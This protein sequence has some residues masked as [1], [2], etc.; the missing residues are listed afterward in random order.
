MPDPTPVSVRLIEVLQEATG[1]RLTMHGDDAALILDDA[2]VAKVQDELRSAMKLCVNT[3]NN[4]WVVTDPAAL[5]VH[6]FSIRLA[7]TGSKE[8][9]DET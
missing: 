4:G 8:T 3:A 7:L 6:L 2:G 5:A 9:S 1:F